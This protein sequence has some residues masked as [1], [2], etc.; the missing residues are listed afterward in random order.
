MAADRAAETIAEGHAPVN[1]MVLGGQL[2]RYREAA[3][4]T[5]AEAGNQIRASESKISRL[6]LG[7]VATKARDVQDLLAYYGVP[8][9]EVE[10]L[11][12]LQH[13]STRNPRWW[14]AYSDLLWKKFENYIGLE[15]SAVRIY[16]FEPL[17]VPGLM[18]TERYAKSVISRGLPEAPA[19]EIDRRVALRMRR[20]RLL[21]RPKAPRLWAV[22]DE[23]VL[24]RRIG[25]ESVMAE[26]LEQL[27]TL[28]R[29]PNVSI[30]V[31]PFSVGG[32]AAEGSF[33]LLRFAE[34]DLPDIVYIEHL[35]GS[36]HLE[37][38]AETEPYSKATHRLAVDA[39]TPDESRKLLVKH[40]KA[41]QQQS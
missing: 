26:Q 20:Q 10:D 14:N 6:E 40:M 38:P 34:P 41:Y 7:R 36:V 9:E 8:A 22:I 11:L 21:G 37:K 3:G 4:V 29:A 12:Q 32:P 2:R 24:H 33:T 30:Q 17:V 18:Q 31:L 1:R 35:S 5:R 13:D 16:S 27:L 25:D 39:L 28:T 15:E 23:A 19:D